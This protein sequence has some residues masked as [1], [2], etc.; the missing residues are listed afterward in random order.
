GYNPFKMAQQQ[1]DRIAEQLD[2]DDAL[3]DLLREPLREYH[4]NIPVKMDD[5]ST[6]VFRGFRVQHNDALGPCKGGIRFHPEETG[7]TVRALAMWMT[8]KTAVADLPLGGGKGGVICDPHDLSERE[9]ERL[10]REYIKKINKNIGPLQ[11][12]PA[13]DVMT[14]PQHMLWMMDEYENIEGGKYPGVITGKPQDMGGSKGRTEATGYGLVYQLRELLKELDR[15]IEETTASIQGF[16]NVAQYAAELFIE[17]GGT[18]VSV[19]CW[20]QE[21]EKPY[22]YYKEDGIDLEELRGITDRFGSIDK[23]KAEEKGYQRL[24]GDEWLTHEVDV[25]IPAALENAISEDNVNDIPDAVD[26]I[27]SGANGPITPEADEELEDRDIIVVPDFLANA[28]GVMC[29]YFEQVQSNQNYY[30]SKE[31]VLGKLDNGM[32]DAFYEVWELAQSKDVRLRDAAYMIAIQ[33]VAEAC[34]ARGWV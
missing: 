24:S 27:I 7:D 4:F 6:K 9:Q 25:L 30:W 32:T 15:D 20:D 8:W 10:C 26:I 22:S 33:R 31:E 19:S 13:P 2:L 14:S 34:E 12:V 29:S 16:G 1:F 18:V 17:Y 3:R 23:E 11:D 21:D 28:G 5:G